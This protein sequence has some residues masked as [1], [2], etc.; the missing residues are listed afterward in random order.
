[1]YKTASHDFVTDI[2]ISTFGLA[3]RTNF[4]GK[5]TGFNARV[6]CPYYVA[7]EVVTQSTYGFECDIWSLGVVM[8]QLLSGELPFKGLHSDEILKKVVEGKVSFYGHEW[9]PVSDAAVDL[10]TRMLDLDPV[11]RITAE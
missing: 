6:G 2:V 7:P 10:I 11:S 8:Y 1:M 4:G 9:M 5:D 3:S